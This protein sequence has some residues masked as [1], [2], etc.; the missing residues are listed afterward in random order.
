MGDIS[1][2]VPIVDLAESAATGEAGKE[3]CKA[4]REVGFA[5]IKNHGVSEETIQEA[6]SW[7]SL[8]FFIS[9]AFG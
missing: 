1:Q 6:F 4:L 9:F 3:L 8:F 7:V 5:Y 2:R